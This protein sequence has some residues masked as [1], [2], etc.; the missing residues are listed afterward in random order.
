MTGTLREEWAA[1]SNAHCP[2]G[3]G[4]RAAGYTGH[5]MATMRTSEGT[6]QQGYSVT[7]VDTTVA[8]TNRQT[9]PESVAR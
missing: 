2:V 4:A 6:L 5:S 3:G 9:K 8:C 7:T 1:R